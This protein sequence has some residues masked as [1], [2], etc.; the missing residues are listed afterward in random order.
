MEKYNKHEP[1]KEYR[2][3]LDLSEVTDQWLEEVKR[4]HRGDIVGIEVYEILRRQ[5]YQPRDVLSNYVRVRVGQSA[6][7]TAHIQGRLEDL[8]RDVTPQYLQEPEEPVPLIFLTE[9]RQ[10]GPTGQYEPVPESPDGN[11]AI[12]FDRTEGL[13]K[14]IP[15]TSE[16]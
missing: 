12:R 15:K 13:L 9:A 14:I 6:G 2:I 1:P 7:E 8:R 3:P 5:R 11:V 4:Q 16:N 10:K